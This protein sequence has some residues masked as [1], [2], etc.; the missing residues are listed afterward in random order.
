MKTGTLSATFD[1]QHIQLDEP[2]TLLPHARLL[3]TLLPTEPDP[4][5]DE[6]LRLAAKSLA[7]AYGDNEPNY[8]P[9]RSERGKSALQRHMNA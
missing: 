8:N 1:G 6:F 9:R 5:R 7:R 3:V 2:Y 4:E